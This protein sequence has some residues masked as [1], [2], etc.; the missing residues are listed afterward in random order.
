MGTGARIVCGATAVLVAA[1][2]AWIVLRRDAGPEL[3]QPLQATPAPAAAGACADE[4]SVAEPDASARSAA[5]QSVAPGATASAPSALMVFG[6]VRLP[7]GI[8]P[9]DARVEIRDEWGERRYSPIGGRDSYSFTDLRPGLWT[10]AVRG[11]PG[12]FFAERQVELGDEPSVRV[13]VVLEVA[14]RIAVKLET[15]TGGHPDRAF[16]DDWQGGYRTQITVVPTSTPLP[17]EVSALQ[18]ERARCGTYLPMS[19]SRRAFEGMVP[20]GFSGLLELDRLPPAYANVMLR[21]RVLASAA[22]DATTRELVLVI[23]PARMLDALGGVSLRL[24]AP[25]TGAPI[26][27]AGLSLADRPTGAWANPPQTALE[28]GR[29]ERSRLPPGEYELQ[30]RLPGFEHFARTFEVLAGRTTELGDVLIDEGAAVRGYVVDEEGNG[31]SVPLAWSA[32]AEPAVPR[33]IEMPRSEPDG[34]FVIAELP[35]EGVLLRIQDPQ[36]ALDPALVRFAPGRIG[37]VRLV[38]RR[39]TPVELRHGFPADAEVLI[40]LRRGDGVAIW[41]ARD[42]GPATHGANLPEGDYVLEA[43]REGKPLASRKF[44]VANERMRVD[45][46]P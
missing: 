38:A 41:S 12:C 40:V 43:V 42:L 34:E 9:P 1:V 20:P 28:D 26:L 13:D 10:L 4:L 36:W 8:P 32:L 16:M 24:V 31:L 18:L 7:A 46:V 39:G 37:E 22:I 15:P 33:F 25:S 21:G 45:L 27:Q 5:R 44:H 19:D 14:P 29:F 2:L 30:V 17:D 23:D 11:Y 3:A 35:P 6:S